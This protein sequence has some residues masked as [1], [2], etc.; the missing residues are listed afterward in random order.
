[1]ERMKDTEAVDCSGE[2]ASDRTF[3][4]EYPHLQ[5]GLTRLYARR[6]Q[7]QAF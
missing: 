5:T 3:L 2:A 6:A 4:V 7:T 1:M